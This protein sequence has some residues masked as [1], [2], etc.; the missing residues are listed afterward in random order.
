LPPGGVRHFQL[1]DVQDFAGPADRQNPPLGLPLSRI[2]VRPESV[3]RWKN[4]E[5]ALPMDLLGE[6]LAEL[7]YE[8]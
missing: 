2:V 3:G 8:G 4:A 1:A 5:G 6:A 7:G